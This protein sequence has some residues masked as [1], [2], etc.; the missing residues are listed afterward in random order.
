MT[1]PITVPDVLACVYLG[2]T[3]AGIRPRQSVT[4]LE[5][6]IGPLRDSDR[7]IAG[8]VRL[9][10]GRDLRLAAA[11]ALTVRTLRPGPV[12]FHLGD[13]LLDHEVSR[14]VLE[15]EF[16]E[17]A[18]SRCSTDDV[19]RSDRASASS[20]HVRVS[21]WAGAP[22]DLVF[23]VGDPEMAGAETGSLEPRATDLREGAAAERKS[24]D[25]L[26]RQRPV[27]L[28]VDLLMGRHRRPARGRV[29]C[30]LETTEETT[31]GQLVR[32][33]LQLNR[34]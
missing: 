10:K 34:E 18:P 24:P 8:A 28:I 5:E 9:D 3:A 12:C 7:T 21:R 2:Q 33:V 30:E 11:I 20:C 22:G 25:P 4:P 13:D 17:L 26:A 29:V 16:G 14:A 27:P 32:A 19:M 15:A 1:A 23:L 6:I 31:D